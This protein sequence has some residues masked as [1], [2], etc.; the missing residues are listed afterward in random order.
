MELIQ[1]LN[2]YL[3]R[4]KLIDTFTRYELY[5]HLGLEKLAYLSIQ[6]LEE[7]YKKLD[8]LNLNIET[9]IVINAMY[10]IISSH[11]K[12]ADFGEKYD[13]YIRA[14]AMSQALQ[15]FAFKDE[16]LNH[17]EIFTEQMHDEIFKDSV[18]TEELKIQFDKYYDSVYA[19]FSQTITKNI[20]EQIRQ[21]VLVTYQ[22]INLK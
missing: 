2:K 16:D 20:A 1:Q 10:Y 18:Y 9:N 6:D 5:F 13:Y 11:Y 21:T 12:D 22:H 14:S 3:E 4:E 19:S 8:Q 7:T 17:P 15:E